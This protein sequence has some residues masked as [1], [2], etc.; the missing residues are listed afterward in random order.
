MSEMVFRG[1]QVYPRMEMMVVSK[2]FQ[3]IIGKTMVTAQ[4]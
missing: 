2:I 3:E 1:W 4:L